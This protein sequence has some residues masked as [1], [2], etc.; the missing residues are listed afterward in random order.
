MR[1]NVEKKIARDAGRDNMLIT[2][3]LWVVLGTCAMA[4]M[5][6]TASNKT[7]V[8]ANVDGEQTGLLQKI[9]E[10]DAVHGKDLL[11][12]SEDTATN[13]LHIPLSKGVKAE[14]VVM[15]N[16]YMERQLW[17]YIENMDESFYEDNAVSGD[18]SRIQK[19]YFEKQKNGVILK[20]QMTGVY[21]YNSTMEGS[22][23]TLVSYEPWEVYKHIIVIDPAGGGENKGPA[24]GEVAEKDVALQVAWLLQKKI[25]LDTCK[26]YFTRL[27]DEDVALEKRARLAREVQ[28]DC[29]IALGV[30]ADETQPD[31][32]GIEGTYNDIYFIPEFGNVQ[33]ADVL[34]K[35]VT[36]AS[37]NRAVGLVPI[38]ETEEDVLK[39]V[40]VPAARIGLGY[41]T[42]EQE[43]R[44]LSQESYL[45]KLAE[46][47][48][49]AVTEVYTN[50]EFA[51]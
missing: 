6:Y 17:I 33:L 37:S 28:A 11:L 4:A 15:E 24:A 43:N 12:Q 8:I 31:L 51:K 16:R 10:D 36:I 13:S 14:D 34:T 5:L 18:I 29:Y 42:N 49:E 45:D 26:L 47:L 46:G 3:V 7:I 38:A 2:A 35:N 50:K 41:V 39:F 44:L 22:N 30:S 25:D 48:A 40:T 19:A 32:Y 20:L 27:S 23:L 9:T 21:E 1:G